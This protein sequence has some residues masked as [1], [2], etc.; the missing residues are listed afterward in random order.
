[1]VLQGKN[2]NYD[3]DIFQS[4]INEISRITSCKY[5]S[6]QE[7]DIAMR[8]V[9]DHI[10]AVS[11]SIAD[12][13]L[14]SNNKAGYV[15]RRILRRAVRYG[16]TFLGQDEPF[17]YKLVGILVK[18]MGEAFPELMTQREL[19]EKV[20]REEEGSFLRTLD[21]GIRMLDGLIADAKGKEQSTIDGRSA[22]VLYDTYGFPF[23]LT[24]LILRENGLDVS[25][26]EFEKG[27]A[28]T[29]IPLQKCS[30]HK[31]RGLARNHGCRINTFPGL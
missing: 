7:T 17:M 18:E 14:P 23:D 24:R 5:G 26:A 1:M 25:Q 3:T 4:L 16:Y 30:I 21:N 15:I 19:I 29:K 9:A 22:F 31:H 20:I 6:A 27:M 8:V 28:V 10:R 11:F 12:G 2:S 13:Q